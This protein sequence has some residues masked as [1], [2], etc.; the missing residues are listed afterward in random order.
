MWQ[1]LFEA[2][3][4]TPKIGWSK[5]T[6]ENRVLPQEKLGIKRIF[7]NMHFCC[8]QIF[9]LITPRWERSPQEMDDNCF[10][11]SSE[12]IFENLG[13]S[14]LENFCHLNF[15]GFS[16][17]S[18]R[19]SWQETACPPSLIN[20]TDLQISKILGIKIMMIMMIM[21]MIL[22]TTL[23]MIFKMINWTMERSTNFL[24]IG[25]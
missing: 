9:E 3:W 25:H 7:S 15:L 18:L 21:M 17:F 20:W 11:I 5:N 16:R 10:M 22:M 23:I 19:L 24:D 2:I 12:D 14:F 6:E 13:N 8:N 4:T 1:A